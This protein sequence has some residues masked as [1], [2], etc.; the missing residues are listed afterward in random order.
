[1]TTNHNKGVGKSMKK[2]Q[3]GIIGFGKSTGHYH[4]PYILNRENFKVKVIYSRSS[5]PDADAEAKYKDRNRSKSWYAT[6]RSW[7][8][9]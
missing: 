5:K 4:L 9:A 7:F 2:L 6:K 8:W 3:I 1:M